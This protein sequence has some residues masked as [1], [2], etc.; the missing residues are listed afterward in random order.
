[1]NDG[2]KQSTIPQLL[3]IMTAIK[4]ARLLPGF[5]KKTGF[6]FNDDRSDCLRYVQPL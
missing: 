4:K 2:W 1:M 6:F 3:L 5:F